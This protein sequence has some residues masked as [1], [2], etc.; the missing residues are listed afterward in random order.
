MTLNCAH[1]G[2][3]IETTNKRKMFCSKS[4]KTLNF[5]K[6]KEIAEPEFLSKSPIATEKIEKTRFVNKK[7][8]NE[9]WQR[10]NEI[11]SQWQNYYDRLMANKN[12][13]YNEYVRLMNYDPTAKKVV[14]GAASGGVAGVALGT[15]IN[16]NKGKNN[17]D[18]VAA[19]GIVGSLLGGAAGYLVAKDQE[20]KEAIEKMNRI[21][22]I[23][24]K[25]HHLEPK[26]NDALYNLNIQTIHL[27]TIPKYIEVNIE[28]TYYELVPIEIKALEAEK[29]A[30]KPKLGKELILNSLDFQ[31][32]EFNTYKLNE[33]YLNI[34]GS[35]LPI[36]S[37]ILIY[38][39]SGH[40]KS[41]W[42]IEL[43]Y[44]IANNLGNVLY[45]SSEEGI[46]ETL[47][48][49]FKGKNSNYLDISEA[50]TYEELK[51]AL[52]AKKY[53]FLVI[54]S[55]N[56]MDIKPNHL[57]ELKLEDPN[58]SIIYIMQATKGGDYKGGTT[59][60]HDSDYVIRISNH[61]AVR[62]KCR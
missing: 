35:N 52:K 26:I 7:L 6:R 51:K 1:C 42:T 49:K 57:K 41:T 61:E 15:G 8:P 43:A 36:P 17:N 45:N 16:G 40:G 55:V 23:V 4:C 44:Y 30:L 28:E 46:G 22:S 39:E 31:N 47:Q 53:A 19:L 9:E 37:N 60:K 13:L 12:N 54:D 50:K 27:S 34:F 18:L 48:R 29:I 10:Q 33:K 38:G 20:Q 2:K 11:V 58:R 3:I 32:K 62:E 21:N 56:D 59:Y 14:I 5:R 24:S 25:S